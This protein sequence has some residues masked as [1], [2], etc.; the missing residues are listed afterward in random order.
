[1]E[2]P[3]PVSALIHAATMVTAGVYLL[4]RLFPVV[5][6]SSTALL[7]IGLVG[8]LTAF[9]AACSALSQR[10]IKRVLAYSTISQMGYLFLAV[11][12]GDI[13]GSLFHLLSHAFFKALLFLA[14]GCIIQALHEEHDIFRMGGLRAQLPQVFWLFL[15]GA[16]SLGAFPLSGGFFSKDRIL[17]AAF[18]HPE[19][20]FKVFW[21]LAAAAALLTPLYI[22]RVLFVAF[23]GD[24]RRR[25]PGPLRPLPRG[26]IGILWPLALLSLFDGLLNLPDIWTGKEWLGQYLS[27]VPGAVAHLRVSPSLE[28]AME[29]GSGLSAL[30]MILLSYR[31]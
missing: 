23:N 5:T 9:F 15:A 29:I 26:M 2:G 13:A 12:A 10:D 20:A 22:F 18:I 1:M 17:L 31:L 6:L 7:V 11:G 24:A 27:T 19:P 25:D 3:T 16:L 30:L 8:A 28:W 14:A 4:M 21:G